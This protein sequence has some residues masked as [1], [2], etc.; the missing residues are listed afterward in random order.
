MIRRISTAHLV[1]TIESEMKLAQMGG[2]E[3]G[4]VIISSSMWNV[5]DGFQ[6]SE[7]YKLAELWNVTIKVISKST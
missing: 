1:A 4:T 2:D 6:Q 3:A 5:L 7:L